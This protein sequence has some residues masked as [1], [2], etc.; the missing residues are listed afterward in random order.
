MNYIGWM[1]CGALAGAGL[2]FLFPIA[3]V[4]LVQWSK[5]NDAHGLGTVAA[6]MV[7]LTVPAGALAGIYLGAMRAKNGT[8]RGALSATSDAQAITLF[9]SLFLLKKF[10]DRR[11]KMVGLPAEEA[12]AAN[13]DYIANLR[14][15][16]ASTKP[17]VPLLVSW[18]VASLIFFPL[19]VVPLALLAKVLG[20]K[21]ILQHLQQ[22]AAQE[23]P[24]A[25]EGN[26]E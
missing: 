11:A 12:A 8:W 4:M 23:W 26:H 17:N 20:T 22:R 5:P 2:G 24:E 19:A 9:Q 6:I 3:L 21:W 10:P 18:G 14:D 7:I 25:A 15:M 1:V 16:D 13:R